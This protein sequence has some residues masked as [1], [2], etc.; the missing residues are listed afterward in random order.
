MNNSQIPGFFN[1]PPYAHLKIAIFPEQSW[2]FESLINQLKGD[3]L[4]KRKENISEN[5]KT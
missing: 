5:A 2:L 4:Q 1:L 3:K